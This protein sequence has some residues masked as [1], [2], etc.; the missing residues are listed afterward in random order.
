MNLRH[1]ITQATFGSQQDG[2][3]GIIAGSADDIRKYC[4]LHLQNEK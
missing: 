4:D 2:N 1:C 3:L